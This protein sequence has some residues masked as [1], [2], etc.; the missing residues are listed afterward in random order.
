MVFL[1]YV[2][3]YVFLIN[4]FY[5]KSRVDSKMIE[6]TIAVGALFLVSEVMGVI[7]SVESNSI[8]H[9]IYLCGKHL[10]QKKNLTHS[11]IVHSV[12]EALVDSYVDH[13]EDNEQAA[14]ECS[15]LCHRCKSPFVP[16]SQTS[17]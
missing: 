3:I 8:I 10:Y 9:F 12:A 5:K 11:T 1:I 17:E 16:I 6:P 2:V 7:R 14:G 15:T 13:G 4:R